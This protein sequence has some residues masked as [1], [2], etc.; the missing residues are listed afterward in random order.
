MT[1]NGTA[2]RSETRSGFLFSILAGDPPTITFALREMPLLF[3]LRLTTKLGE[4]EY[5]IDG[6]T[7]T[8]FKPTQKAKAAHATS[9]KGAEQ[10]R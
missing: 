9:P 10:G 3:A 5:R 2:T 6:N 1:L 4:L 8:V 7:V